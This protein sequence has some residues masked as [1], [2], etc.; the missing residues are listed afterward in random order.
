MFVPPTGSMSI[1]NRVA[2]STADLSATTMPTW[3]RITL[4][5]KK[6]MLNFFEGSSMPSAPFSS[7]RATSI[8]RSPS[9]AGAFGSP[10]AGSSMLPETSS[11][12]RILSENV[13]TP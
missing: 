3:Y 13:V 7:R 8:F 6:M 2:S 12:N 1:A 10:R 4:L 11:T 9:F 5:A